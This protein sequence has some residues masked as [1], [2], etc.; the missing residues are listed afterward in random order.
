MQ[1]LRI[2]EVAKRAA[3]SVPTIW[4]WVRSGIFPEPFALTPNVT[5]WDEV[6]VDKWLTEKKE[7]KRENN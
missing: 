4:N 1:V 7:S 6:D 5:V 3:V 2:K